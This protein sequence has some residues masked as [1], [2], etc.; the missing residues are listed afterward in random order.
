MVIIFRGAYRYRRAIC[1]STQ[2]SNYTALKSY[3]YIEHYRDTAE[4]LV[5]YQSIMIVSFLIYSK[6]TEYP[7]PGPWG[8]QYS[9]AQGKMP[10]LPPSR[11]PCLLVIL[12]LM[13]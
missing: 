1:C 7:L 9:G 6:I 3:K 8:P 2:I 5:R 12:W 11:W 4:Q 10:Q 13:S